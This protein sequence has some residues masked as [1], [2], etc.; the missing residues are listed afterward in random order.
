MMIMIMMVVAVV[1]AAAAAMRTITTRVQCLHLLSFQWPG[2]TCRP[3]R[4]ECYNGDCH[5]SFTKSLI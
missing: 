3:E 1:E 2:W 4:E 5:R